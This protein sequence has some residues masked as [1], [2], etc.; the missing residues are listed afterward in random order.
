MEQR[1]HPRIKL[2][3]LVEI[4]H[5]SLGSHETTAEDLSEGGVFVALKDHQIKVGAVLKVKLKTGL[6]ADA[7][8]SPTVDM[9]VARIGEDGLGLRFKN[10]TAEHLWS[11]VERLREELCIGRDYFQVFADI[12]ILNRKK[13]VLF[14]QRQGKW[15][16]PGCYLVAG[17]QPQ[18]SLQNL[19]Q[20][21]VGLSLDA[22]PAPLETRSLHHQVLPEASTFC[23]T[24]LGETQ[25]A[26]VNLAESYK[27]SRWI[28]KIGDL[29]DLT[30]A[31]ESVRS[32]ARSVLQDLAASERES[33]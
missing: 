14:V 23:C 9:Q 4:K 30:L 16:L 15:T 6:L 20:N 3:L 1:Q 25:D 28:R 7:E 32:T 33:G 11:S 10:K 22:A 5:A 8:H 18:E 2:P 21:D 26:R 13:G 29:M 24:Y 31:Q 19:C 12:M 17:E 27:G